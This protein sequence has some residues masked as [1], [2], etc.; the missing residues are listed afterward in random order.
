M[1]AL[2]RGPDVRTGEQI[3]MRFVA[4]RMAA[5]ISAASSGPRPGQKIANTLQT[6]G[7]LLDR[8]WGRFLAENDFLQQTFWNW[9]GQARSFWHLRGDVH[10]R[11]LESELSLTDCS[12]TL[13]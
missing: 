10:I 5:A 11:C 7:T 2:R 4:R 1:S 6:N 3:R 13:K 12:F 9:G 8:D